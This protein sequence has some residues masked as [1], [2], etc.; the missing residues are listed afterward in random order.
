[1]PKSNGCSSFSAPPL[2]AASG[3]LF[4]TESIPRLMKWAIPSILHCVHRVIQ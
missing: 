1:M 2:Y 3:Y 4:T